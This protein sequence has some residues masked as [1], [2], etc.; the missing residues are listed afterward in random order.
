MLIEHIVNNMYVSNQILMIRVLN[1]TF[2]WTVP[3]GCVLSGW[4]VPLG[5]VLSGRTVPPGCVLSGGT[6]PPGGVLS[7]GTVPPFNLSL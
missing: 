2:F 6:V 1:V 7:S 3:L 4:K 5:C